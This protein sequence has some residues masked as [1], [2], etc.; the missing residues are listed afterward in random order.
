VAYRVEGGAVWAAPSTP[1]P[2]AQLF[3]TGGDQTV[4][5]YKLRSIGVP[6]ANG[7]TAAGKLLAA[8]SI[9]WQRPWA[10]GTASGNWETTLFLDG[11]AVADRASQ[12]KPHWGIGAGVRYLTPVGPLQADLAWGVTTRKLR[13]HVSV[14]FEF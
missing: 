14:G 12:L 6:A 2:D 11:G 10:S 13:L 8:G 7:G 4:R 9:E 3:L 5:G 1:V